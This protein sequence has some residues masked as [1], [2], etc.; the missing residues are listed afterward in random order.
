LPAAP[1][2]Q[3]FAAARAGFV[4]AIRAEAIGRASH[5]LG[6]GRDRVGDP[7]DRAV[8]LKLFVERGAVV[9][10]GQPLLELHHRDGRGLDQA[11]ALCRVAVTI[12]DTAPAARSTLVGE[13]R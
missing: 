13:V 5:V 12:D 11:L 6:A 10:K 1:A 9:S 7:V 4:T 3:T 8:G 2:R